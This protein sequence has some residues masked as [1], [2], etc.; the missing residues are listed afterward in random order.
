MQDLDA[1][2]PQDHSARAIWDMLERLDL[3]GFY[4]SIQS[5]V[6]ASEF[7]NNSK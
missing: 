5:V 3:G 1:T 4:T 2:L 7:V 6:S